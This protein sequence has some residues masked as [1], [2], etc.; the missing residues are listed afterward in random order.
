MSS[1]RTDSFIIINAL[2][3]PLK[4]LA[5]KSAVSEINIAMPNFF[6]TNY[7]FSLVGVL[8]LLLIRGRL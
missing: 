8:L 1:Q 6:F 3:Y 4:L 7:I 5:L 2:H